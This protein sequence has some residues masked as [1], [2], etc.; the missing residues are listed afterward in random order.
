MQLG[1][2]VLGTNLRN[3]RNI[4]NP[5]RLQQPPSHDLLGDLD[6]LCSC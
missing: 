4:A 1:W 2:T 3:A 5:Q 6:S